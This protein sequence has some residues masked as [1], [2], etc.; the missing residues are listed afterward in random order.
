MLTY[1]LFILQLINSYLFN[2]QT[3][4]TLLQFAEETSRDLYYKM[5]R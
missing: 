3:F 4:W 5:S 1:F 2:Y